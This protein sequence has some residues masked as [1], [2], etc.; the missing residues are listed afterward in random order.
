DVSEPFIRFFHSANWRD[1]ALRAKTAICVV[2]GAGVD[3]LRGSARSG[4]GAEDT[5][6]Q[7]CRSFIQRLQS[8]KFRYVHRREGAEL[9]SRP[10]ISGGAWRGP[11]LRQNN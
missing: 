7:A 9:R 4:D 2:E 10:C 8:E 3:T 11:R 1:H 5:A 6:A